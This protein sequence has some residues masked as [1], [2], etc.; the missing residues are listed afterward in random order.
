[1]RYKVAP[2]VRSRA[3]LE[4]C[5]EAVPLIPDSEADCCRAI[6]EA[7]DLDNRETAREYLVLCQ[8]LGLVAESDR[9][10]YR[11][12]DDPSR[13]ELAA[14]FRDHVF[15]ATELVAAVEGGSADAADEDEVFDAIR[16]VVP[17][18]ERERDPDWE[19]VWRERTAHLLGWA[20]ELGLLE[21]TDAGYRPA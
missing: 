13:D 16:D 12:Q 3:F 21:A 9:G 1:M 2:P 8:A 7:T 10:Y 17:Q 14:A 20:A 4:Q 5:R 18:W 6:R 15:A 19:S 11:T